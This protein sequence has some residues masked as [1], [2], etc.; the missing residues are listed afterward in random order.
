MSESDQKE[1]AWI[2]GIFG[3]DT[4]SSDRRNLIEMSVTG[5]AT[6]YY[7]QAIHSSIG[8]LMDY[9]KNLGKTNAEVLSLMTRMFGGRDGERYVEPITPGAMR[10]GGPEE[11][12]RDQRFPTPTE[13]AA[14]F[15]IWGSSPGAENIPLD[16][17]REP[18]DYSA[19][20]EMAFGPLE[21][22]QFNQQANPML[23]GLPEDDQNWFSTNY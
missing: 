9:H 4:G 1:L 16:F 22:E 12:E 19:S 14:D 15:G 8:K 23:L 11:M 3:G 2:D 7:S 10:A 20:Q 17:T 6:D 5:G 18:S 13:T 21:M